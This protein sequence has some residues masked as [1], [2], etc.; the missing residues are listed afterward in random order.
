M[1]GEMPYS[2]QHSGQTFHALGWGIS[3]RYPECGLQPIWPIEE[4]LARTKFDWRRQKQIK[5][6]NPDG[7]M[8]SDLPKGVSAALM[9]KQRG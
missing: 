8:E 7:N 4:F 2:V 5:R 9:K 3:E 6:L 1:R